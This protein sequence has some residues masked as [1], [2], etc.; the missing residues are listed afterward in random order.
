[1]RNFV[2]TGTPLPS[3]QL[4]VVPSAVVNVIDPW[5]MKRRNRLRNKPFFP[6]TRRS[7]SWDADFPDFPRLSHSLDREPIGS[8][9]SDLL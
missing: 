7:A 8:W 6:T 1:M 9:S 3:P 5:R 4:N 2:A